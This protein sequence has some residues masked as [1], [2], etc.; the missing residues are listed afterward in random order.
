MGGGNLTLPAQ[1][2]RGLGSIPWA[3]HK[4]GDSYVK[5]GE[6]IYGNV[7]FSFETTN[8]GMFPIIQAQELAHPALA[9]QY[10][11]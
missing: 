9:E 6:T 7:R 8:A 5:F 1:N 10:P 11:Y 3:V 2:A 4:V